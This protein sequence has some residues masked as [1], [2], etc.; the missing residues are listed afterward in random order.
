MHAVKYIR[1]QLRTRRLGKFTQEEGAEE[2]WAEPE[3]SDVEDA[4][5][6]EIREE[7][8][9]GK[10]LKNRDLRRVWTRKEHS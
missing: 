6:T 10:K 2:Q 4:V 7:G 3:A 1:E 8:F 5:W 9:A